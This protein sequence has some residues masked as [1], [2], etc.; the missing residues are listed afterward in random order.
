M[1]AMT[2]VRLREPCGRLAFGGDFWWGEAPECPAPPFGRT[3][4]S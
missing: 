1:V 4:V 3:D 2:P